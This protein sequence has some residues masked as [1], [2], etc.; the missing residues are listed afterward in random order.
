MVNSLS[1]MILSLMFNIYS[2][3]IPVWDFST[4]IF[5]MFTTTIN[6]PIVY[7]NSGYTVK[8]EFIRND[9]G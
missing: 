5:D 6:E 8:N 1:L 4:S 9:A 7:E 2:P 3:A